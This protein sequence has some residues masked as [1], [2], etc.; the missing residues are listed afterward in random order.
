MPSKYG[1]S[2]KRYAYR[3]RLGVA[4]RTFTAAKSRK[5]TTIGRRWSAKNTKLPYGINLGNALH[6]D[7]NVI[8][9]RGAFPQQMH[10][11]LRYVDQLYLTA[12]NLTG[13]T[14]TEIPYR[15][16]GCF[17]PYFLAGGHQPLGW[18]QITPLYQR[19]KVYKVEIQVR[20]LGKIGSNFS[21]VGTNL[22][23]GASTYTLG[24][25]KS[26]SEVMEQPGNTILDGVLNQSWNT[27]VWPHKIEGLSYDD[28][29]ISK[30]YSSLVTTTPNNTPFLGLVC[31]TTDEPASSTNGIYVSV[32]LVFHTMFYEP[33]PLNQS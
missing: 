18:D 32:G 27:T 31:G 10:V 14:G 13:R 21:Y 30:E 9:Q 28:Y 17:D 2:R 29:M 5:V 25:L 15:L 26:V 23:H 12:D 22:R 6:V 3:R 20:V 24:S 1:F 8:N 7:R 19:Y 4:R 16:N 11:Q 33:N